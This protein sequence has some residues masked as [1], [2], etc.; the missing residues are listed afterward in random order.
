MSDACADT[1]PATAEGLAI[2][3][4]AGSVAAAAGAAVAAN[5]YQPATP[6]RAAWR[7]GYYD[8]LAADALAE[9]RAPYASVTGD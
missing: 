7:D 4:R 9:L 3:Y 5:P 6:L 1:A 8:R 2:A